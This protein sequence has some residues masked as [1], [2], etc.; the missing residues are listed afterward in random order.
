MSRWVG[1]RTK[2]TGLGAASK[3]DGEL[4]SIE[5]ISY[6]SNPRTH[7]PTDPRTHPC[8][9]PEGTL[10]QSPGF[11]PR[12]MP[13]PPIRRVL[14]GRRTAHVQAASLQDATRIWSVYPRLKPWAL[15]RRAFSTNATVQPTTHAPTDPRI[16]GST[17]PRT[18]GPTEPRSHG[19]TEPRTHRPTHSRT[20]GPTHSRTHG[21]TDPPTHG[22]TD[23]PTHR[24]KSEPGGRRL[25]RLALRLQWCGCRSER[26]MRQG[27]RLLCRGG[28]HRPSVVDSP[29]RRWQ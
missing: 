7:G 11:Q 3:S 23:S 24:L 17:D 28:R 29:H 2:H 27:L 21:P 10:G 1:R 6:L 25:S 22:S 8:E 9:R 18:H 5:K 20:H 19:P 4:Y 15:F 26:S 12:E 16:H 13:H 14:K